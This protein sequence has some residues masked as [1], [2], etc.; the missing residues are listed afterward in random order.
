MLITIIKFLIQLS[1]LTTTKYTLIFSSTDKLIVLQWEDQHLQPQQ[2]YACRVINNC[3]IYNIT[4]F[5]NFEGIC[6]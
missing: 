1:A 6:S 5:K 4:P 2:S 3:Y